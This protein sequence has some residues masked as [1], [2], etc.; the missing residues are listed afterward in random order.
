MMKLKIGLALGLLLGLSAGGVAMLTP[1]APMDPVPQAGTTCR[2]IQ[3]GGQGS[4][5][6]GSPRRSAAAGG[7][8]SP[9]HAALSRRVRG[10]HDSRVN[11]RSRWQDHRR[12]FVSWLVAVRRGHR[13]TNETYPS[14]LYVF[15]ASRFL[16]GW[17]TAAGC[18]PGTESTSQQKKRRANLGH[19]QWKKDNRG[20][21][22]QT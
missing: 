19:S 16:S 18:F 20:R 4:G 21:V 7:R 11:V 5:A 14:P 13:Q 6:S 2:A 17:Q 9:G 8:G 22:E 1:R 15:L 12:C 3:S 10:E